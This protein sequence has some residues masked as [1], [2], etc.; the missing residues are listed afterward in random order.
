MLYPLFLNL[1]GASAL[2]VGAGSVASAKLPALLAARAVIDV[3]APEAC[4][5]VEEWARAGALRHVARGFVPTDA[6]GRRV[7]IAATGHSAVNEAVLRACRERGIWVNVVDD[8]ERCDF[9]APAVVTR[10]R[11]Q[12]AVSTEGASPAFAKQLR[13]ELETTLHPSLGEYVELLSEARSRIRAR[14]PLPT[15]RR[16]ANEALLRTEARRCLERGDARGA[17]AAVD[18]VLDDIERKRA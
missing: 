1:A 3:V 14:L 15:E 12:V 13:R 2:V 6:D 5:A 18:R 7:V 9:F 8:P 17:S 4:A 16:A 10:G 11:L